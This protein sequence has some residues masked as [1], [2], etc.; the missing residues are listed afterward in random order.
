[1]LA[2]LHAVMHRQTLLGLEEL[3]AAVGTP[4][5][6]VLCETELS[7]ASEMLSASTAFGLACV[8]Q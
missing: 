5:L 2:V 7:P 3:E 8:K 1:M 6:V 4:A